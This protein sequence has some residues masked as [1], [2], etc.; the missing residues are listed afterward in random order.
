MFYIEDVLVMETA[1]DDM[2][3]EFFPHLLDRLLEAGA[4]D[5]YL[6]PVVMKKGRVGTMLTVLARENLQDTLLQ[7]IFSETPTLGVRL[8]TERR[9]CLYR[10]FITVQTGYGT[11]RV[12]LALEGTGG[13]PLRYAPEYEDCLA[14]AKEHGVPV[15][16][17]YRAA[18]LAAEDMLKDEK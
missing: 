13:R 3:P 5:A 14:R 9:A 10:D 7:V 4:L 8:R 15:Q 6:Q 12:K 17:V 1:I 18:L 16:S 2:N 11:L